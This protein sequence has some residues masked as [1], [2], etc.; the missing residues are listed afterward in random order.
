M[1]LVLN[2]NNT[3]TV[4]ALY[5]LKSDGLTDKLRATWRISTRH[6]QTADEYGIL[7]R[8]L[9]HSEGVE[10]S[11]IQSVVIAS[12]VPPVDWVLRQ[13][14]ERYFH[15]KPL[16]IEPG[17]KTGLPILT[18]NPS[19]VGADRVANCVGA[20]AKYGGP[21]IV[22]DFGT[23]TNFDVVSHKGEFLG[24]AIAPGLNISAEAL[25]ARAAR[26]PR[27]EIKRPAKIIGTNTV[28]NL[29]IGLFYGHI[30]LV[31]FILG[32]MIAKLGEG[33]KC[34]ATGGLAHLIASE[35]KYIS[36]IDDMLTLDGLRIIHDRNRSAKS[37]AHADETNRA[38]S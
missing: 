2:V 37:H 28:D 36:E 17:V 8:S 14:C 16:F 38:S 32:R 18:D 29:Q 21:T 20:F 12:V 23:A 26:L 25:F 24:G 11:R 9:L 35:S 27:V 19:E 13:F 6:G 30:G 1:L 4:I 5:T 22:V 7:V 31:D 34:I 3:N 15:Q 33:T 10:S